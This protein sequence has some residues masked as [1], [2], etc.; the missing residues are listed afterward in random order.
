MRAEEGGWATEEGRPRRAAPTV[1]HPEIH[2]RS[3]HQRRI[4]P[5]SIHIGGTAT[6]TH[7]LGIHPRRRD[8]TNDASPRNSPKPAEPPHRRIAP[9]PIQTG[10]TAPTTHRPGIHPNR[11]DRINDASPRNSSKPAGPTYNASPRNSSK[12]AKPHQR[13]IAPEP[14]QTGGIAPTRHC[15]RIHPNRRGGPAWPPFLYGRPAPRNP[16]SVYSN[17]AALRSGCTYNSPPWES[18]MTRSG[19]ST[20]IIH[21]TSSFLVSSSGS[22]VTEIALLDSLQFF[23]RFMAS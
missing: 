13:R 12:P 17:P 16:S 7:R 22:H 9:E 19:K 14:I 20:K 1:H 5:K 8:R 15:P 3:P 4:A 2:H 23:K 10:G 18:L 11:R 21:G 6:T